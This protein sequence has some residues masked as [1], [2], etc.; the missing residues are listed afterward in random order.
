MP[1]VAVADRLI[2]Y[3]LL[4]ILVLFTCLLGF[5]TTYATLI[6]LVASLV[7]YI[8]AFRTAQPM[9]DE[10]AKSFIAA[11]ITIGILFTLSAREPGDVLYVFN[12]VM[13]ATYPLVAGF[14][15]RGA[16]PTNTDVFAR[17]ALA[18]AGIGMIIALYDAFVLQLARA[19]SGITDPIRLGN[20]ALILGFLALLGFLVRKDQW[21]WVY[22]A[23]PAFGTMT[24]LLAGARGAIIAFPF[25]LVAAIFL[26]IERKRLALVLAGG[27]VLAALG[28]LSLV[29]L[30]GADRLASI[31]GVIND[32]ASG[33]EVADEAVRVRLELYRAGW[34][35]FAEA[36]WFGHGWAHVMPD[37]RIHLAKYYSDYAASLPHLHNE[38]TQ[39]AVAG[40]V[41]GIC[42]LI[43]L[44]AAPIIACLRSPR[45]SQYRA[46]MAGC[47]MLV[48]A[49][50]GMGLPDTMVG[51]ELHTTLYVGLT[52]ALISFCRDRPARAITPAARRPDPTATT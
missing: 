15:D 47:V 30:M 44:L 9:I 4:A 24:I 33:R 25:L 12:F 7:F 41:F 11:F 17:L 49:Y 3:T 22:L 46:R 26:L 19:G 21:R 35:A 18:G 38:V 29:S 6:M 52:A 37:T 2:R 45:D 16:R 36:P 42:V 32:L 50:V 31:F 5:A 1:L 13:L 40:G 14:F 23:G 28:G 43:L 20:T 27:L 34:R 39:F 10:A 48:V 8:V 51:F